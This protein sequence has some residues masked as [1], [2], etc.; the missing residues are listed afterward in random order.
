MKPITK[1]DQ[2]MRNR[3]DWPVT[4]SGLLLVILVM[5]MAFKFEKVE[6]EWTSIGRWKVTAY[7]ACE[8]CCGKWADGITAS[9]HRLVGDEKVIAAPI[10]FKFG[11]IMDVEQYGVGVVLDRCDGIDV[12]FP[13]HQEALE[14][15]I[16]EV[17]VRV[18]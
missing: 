17:E 10:E 14:W 18:R 1:R 8:K 16:K 3:I 15:G 4:I 2:R 11:T 13:S 5:L 9:G 12:Y 6:Q 7:C